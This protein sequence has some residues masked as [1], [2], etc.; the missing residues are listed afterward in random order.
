[1]IGKHISKELQIFEATGETIKDI[2]LLLNSLSILPQTSM[3]SELLNTTE[4][5][6]Y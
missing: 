5:S 1:M 2:K 6:Q 3:E 4:R